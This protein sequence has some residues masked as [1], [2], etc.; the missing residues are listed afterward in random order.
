MAQ[1]W[2]PA[3]PVAMGL[4]GRG[5]QPPRHPLQSGEYCKL[6][7][8]FSRSKGNFE[9]SEKK[10]HHVWSRPSSLSGTIYC[11]SAVSLAFSYGCGDQR[12]ISTCDD[13]A[14]THVS[15][16]TV[17]HLRRNEMYSQ[18][19]SQRNDLHSQYYTQQHKQHSRH[20]V[21]VSVNIYI[22]QTPTHLPSFTRN[23]NCTCASE[24]RPDAGSWV[25]LSHLGRVWQLTG[26]IGRTIRKPMWHRSA[27]GQLSSL[28]SRT[29]WQ[30]L[31]AANTPHTVSPA[32]N[33]CHFVLLD[34]NESCPTP[35][36]CHIGCPMVRPM[37]CICWTHLTGRIL[38]A[39][40]SRGRVE[41]FFNSNFINIMHMHE[42]F[43][44]FS[45][46]KKL[47]CFSLHADCLSLM[48]IYSMHELFFSSCRFLSITGTYK[49]NIQCPAVMVYSSQH[50]F[51]WA[52][53]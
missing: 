3:G 25:C 31:P 27:V 6:R 43:L 15:H 29:K 40:E 11:Y 41:L 45:Y 32:G 9:L 35:D 49:Y 42:A 23:W 47:P 19:S 13:S 37:A 4:L 44:F 53:W 48:K 5:Q 51:P 34:K 12:I 39:H 38:P 2:G 30:R 52:C 28:S 10:C 18:M 16:S 24:C 20:Q 17:P 22:L 26:R 50:M 7:I 8:V 21:F 33:R 14:N 46:F 36:L 1:D